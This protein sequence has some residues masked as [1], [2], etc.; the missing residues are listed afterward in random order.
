[1]QIRTVGFLVMAA[2]VAWQSMWI[3][4][5]FVGIEFGP[6]WVWVPFGV[7]VGMATT[8]QEQWLNMRDSYMKLVNQE[9]KY[10][11]FL[12][13]GSEEEDV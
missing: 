8:S 7:G 3:G 1:M 11:T 9:A 2:V 5:M 13:S 6:S 10:L 12:N 4:S